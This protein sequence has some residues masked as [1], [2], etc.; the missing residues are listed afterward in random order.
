VHDPN[1]SFGA[2]K[3][4]FLSLKGEMRLPGESQQTPGSPMQQVLKPEDLEPELHFDNT[5]HERKS[6]APL[7]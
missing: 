4:C 7:F 5:L 2:K 1:G 6:I 3:V